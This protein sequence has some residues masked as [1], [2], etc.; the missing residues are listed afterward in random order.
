[1]TNHGL[2]EEDAMKNGYQI[3]IGPDLCT[4]N[5]DWRIY[6]IGAGIAPE[7]RPESS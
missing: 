4:I 2:H 7:A 1:M 6:E 3:L 5:V